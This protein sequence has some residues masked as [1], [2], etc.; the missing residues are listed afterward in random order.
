[1]GSKRT[2]CQHGLLNVHPLVYW[3][4]CSILHVAGTGEQ[5]STGQHRKQVRRDT[6][7]QISG[8]SS[9]GIARYSVHGF[10]L[11]LISLLRRKFHIYRVREKT[12]RQ[13]FG[14]NFDKF[15]YIVVIFC[16]KYREGNAKLLTQQKSTS[17]N[18]CHHFTLRIRQWPC[19]AKCK[20]IND[21]C[22]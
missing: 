1:M 20:V 5:W 17:P 18:Q 6:T 9:A 11:L 3:E 2:P 13:Y 15:K 4:I 7:G 22:N 14:H 10:L 16:K 8:V 21:N 12:D 19:I